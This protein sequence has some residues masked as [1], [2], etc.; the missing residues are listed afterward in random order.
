MAW[1]VDS[2][3]WQQAAK[4]IFV[5]GECATVVGTSRTVQCRAVQWSMVVFGCLFDG[6]S[7]VGRK[8]EVL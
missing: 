7:E 1:V 8:S 2:A 4:K 5:C 6:K 3:G